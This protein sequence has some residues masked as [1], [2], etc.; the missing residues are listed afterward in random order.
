MF[1]YCLV[2]LRFILQFQAQHERSKPW[3]RWCQ[4]S[5]WRTTLEP[6]QCKLQ[7]RLHLAQRRRWRG[8][9]LPEWSSGDL[10]GIARQHRFCICVCI[11]RQRC[12]TWRTPCGG[13]VVASAIQHHWGGPNPASSRG[14][15]KLGI[16]RSAGKLA[17][18]QGVDAEE[19]Q[20]GPSPPCPTWSRPTGTC[21]AA[22]RSITEGLFPGQ[23]DAPSRGVDPWEVLTVARRPGYSGQAEGYVGRGSYCCECSQ[24]MGGVAGLHG[25][26]GP[27]VP[28][29]CT[30]PLWILAERNVWAL[31][32][33]SLTE[34]VFQAW[35]FTMGFQ[36]C[37]STCS[38]EPTQTGKSGTGS[39]CWT[40]DDCSSWRT[41]SSVVWGRGPPLEGLTF[42]LAGCF[43]CLAVQAHHACQASESDP[44]LFSRLLPKGQAEGQ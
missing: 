40:S 4:G 19:E 41:H 9:L 37:T 28:A 12:G 20:D 14:G 38:E 35:S 39:C 42:Q 24:I 26:E 8:W 15:R 32:S 31:S 43:R 13:C 17:Y 30:G 11:L 27:F 3:L 18:A 25:A 21:A 2:I 34:M 33:F 7:V 16:Q 23:S 5:P 29:G 36:W 6:M 1:V 10:S 44:M 22:S